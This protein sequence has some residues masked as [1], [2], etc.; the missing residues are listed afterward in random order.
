M[1]TSQ[2]LRFVDGNSNE[3][4]IQQDISLRPRSFEEF[5]GQSE[6]KHN[7]KVFIEASKQR[8]EALDHVLFYGPPGLG[9]TTLSQI[10]AIQLATEIK[11]TSGPVLSKTGDLAAILTNLKEREVLFIDEIH[12]LP[13]AVEEVLYSA[14][15]DF[16]LDLIIGEGPAARAV[17]ISLPKFTLIGATTRLGLLSN[18]LRD[19]FGIPMKLDFYTHDE[20]HQVLNRYAKILQ[21]DFDTQALAE[22]AKSARGTPRIAVRLIKRIRDFAQYQKLQTIDLPLVHTTLKSLDIDA[23]GL[24][25]FDRSYLNYINTHYRG[26]PVG[27]E[28]IAAGMSEDKETIEDTIEP[29][30][31]QIGFIARTPRGR[32]LTEV[33]KQYLGRVRSA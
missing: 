4:D 24:D 28:T 32:V 16:S 12:R 33:C 20:L 22:L 23:L 9:K 6:L 30:L 13:V 8:G 3:F 2:P 15:E 26:G 19:R 11:I 25:K 27:I 5:I 18:P 7:L 1:N 10:I 31:L 29:Y 21:L 14:M 17:K